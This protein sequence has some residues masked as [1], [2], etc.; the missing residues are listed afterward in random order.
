M[1]ELLGGCIC[2]TLAAGLVGT[3]EQVERLF[4]PDLVIGDFRL[5]LSVS[6]RVAGVPYIAIANS[7]WSP[8][9]RPR[10]ELAENVKL[11][12]GLYYQVTMDKSIND[13]KDETWFT[14]GMSYEF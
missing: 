2:C 14:L 11:T 12:P 1:Q 8:F 7:W 10:F 3:L 6:A 13:D 4:Q 9:G 5:S